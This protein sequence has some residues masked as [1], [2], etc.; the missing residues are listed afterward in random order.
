MVENLAKYD[1][2]ERIG[3]SFNILKEWFYNSLGRY[4]FVK[5]G[6]FWVIQIEWNYKLEGRYWYA[7]MN[8]YKAGEKM[9]GD[10]NLTGHKYLF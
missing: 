6:L 3:F 7:S 10:E 2:S 4:K 1:T 9:Y 8:N 5:N